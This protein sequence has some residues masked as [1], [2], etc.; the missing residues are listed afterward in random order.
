MFRMMFFFFSCIYEVTNDIFSL[1]ITWKEAWSNYF[2][3]NC[4]KIDLSDLYTILCVVI[5]KFYS[6]NV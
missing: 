4:H 2:R 3:G 6:C 1:R 5:V